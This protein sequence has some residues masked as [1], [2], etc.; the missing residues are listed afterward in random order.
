MKSDFQQLTKVVKTGIQSASASFIKLQKLPA[1]PPKQNVITK[2]PKPFRIIIILVKNVR[3][4][5][6]KQKHQYPVKKNGIQKIRLKISQ[7]T[8]QIRS[9]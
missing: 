8:H 5:K 9:I 3:Y 2:K 4:K 1:I 7:I 6:S